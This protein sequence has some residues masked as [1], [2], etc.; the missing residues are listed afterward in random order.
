MATIET[1]SQHLCF[2][3]IQGYYQHLSEIIGLPMR[4]GVFRPPHAGGARLPALVYLAGLTCTE[5]TFAMKA[6]AQR[7]AADQGIVLVMPD[8]SP[9][10]TGVPDADADWYPW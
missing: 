9:R 1:R 2:G 7:W 5:E 4:F 10:D 6:G 3:G 8:T